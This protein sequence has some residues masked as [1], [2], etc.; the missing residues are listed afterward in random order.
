MYEQNFGNTSRN[1][2]NRC[3]SNPSVEFQSEF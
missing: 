1:R 3:D 2:N